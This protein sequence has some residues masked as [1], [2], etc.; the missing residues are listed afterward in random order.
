MGGMKRSV[1]LRYEIISTSRYSVSK[2]LATAGFLPSLKQTGERKM[3]AIKTR[4][5][6]GYLY[7]GNK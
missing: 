3:I 4:N 6:G 5:F 2:Y 7:Y 1:W